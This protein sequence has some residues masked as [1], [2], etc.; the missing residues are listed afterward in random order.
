[1]ELHHFDAAPGKKFYAATLAPTLP[2]SRPIFLKSKKVK[3]IFNKWVF[4]IAIVVNMNRTI[5]YIFSKSIHVYHCCAFKKNFK[6]SR[7]GRIK[8]LTF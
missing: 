5:C 3:I 8:I 7:Q 2:Y 1:V 6:W 4:M